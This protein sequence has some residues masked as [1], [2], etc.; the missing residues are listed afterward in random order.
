M[1]VRLAEDRYFDV[2]WKRQKTVDEEH[3]C[4]RVETSC[5]VGRIDETSAKKRE[6]QGEIAIGI[7][8]QGYNDTHVKKIGRKV[9][10]ARALSSYGFNKTERLAFWQKYLAS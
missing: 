10:L 3:E 2:W 5:M 1:K 7:T 6:F 8:L 9:S 4:E